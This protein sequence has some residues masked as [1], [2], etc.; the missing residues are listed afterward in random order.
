MNLAPG[1]E[2]RDLTHLEQLRE[3]IEIEKRVWGYSDAEEAVPLPM[4]AAGVRRGAIV[5]G[6]FDGLAIAGATYSFP[7]IKDRRATHWSHMLGVLE[8]YRDRGVG[9]LLKLRQRERAL[10]MGIDL[11]EWTFDP[12]QAAN[13]YFNLARLGAVV[14]QHEVN[15]YGSSSSPLWRGTESDRFVAQWNIREPHVERRLTR[16]GPIIRGSDTLAAACVLEARCVA[17]H[18]APGEPNLE[19]ESRR[20]RVEIPAS[21]APIR[22]ERPDLAA[23][24]R[25]TTR[26]VFTT[27]LP[28]GYRVVDFWFERARAC[29]SYLL[30]RRD[31]AER[32]EA[33]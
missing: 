12:L 10:A 4:L 26:A 16:R 6:A 13:G 3:V 30:A 32:R 11:I 7:A 25:A 20:L 19:D 22:V 14:E 2:I 23:L 24:W 17:G 15:F 21:F 9:R 31:I 1:I 27:Y 18:V 29:G 28:R 33:A 5:L 8:P